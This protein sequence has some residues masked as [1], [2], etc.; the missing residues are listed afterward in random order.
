MT[1][2][3]E[4]ALSLQPLRQ[5]YAPL[6]W[7]AATFFAIAFLTRLVLLIKTGD[8]VPAQ[9]TSWLYLFLVGA[10]YDL[11]A[12]VYFAWPLVLFL[13][14]VPQRAYATRPTRAILALLSLASLYVLMFV[15]AAEWLFWD[16][17]ASRFNF[18]AVD[19]LVYSREV[20]G[21]IRASYPVG[22]LL[23][24][25]AIVAAAIVYFTRGGWLP[26]ADGSRLRARSLVTAAWLVLTIAF[27]A[28]VDSDD[29]NRSSNAYVNELAG[30]GIYEFFSA[31]RNNEL[32]YERLYKTLPDATA[33]AKVRELLQTP[34][35][36]FLSDD[37]HDIS[38]TIAN[39]GPEKHL[40]VVLISV[41]SLS[42]EYLT[43]FG[44]TKGITPNLDALVD[45]SLFFDNLYASGTR[46]VRGLE[47]LSLSV[48]PTPG[49][50]I[51]KRPDNEHLFSLGS[52]FDSKGYDSMFVYG[53]YGYFDNMN[54]FFEN[55]GYRIADRTNIPRDKVHLGNIWGVADEDL[56]TLAMD[57]AD[58][59]FASG[60][61][62][63]QHVM[64]TSNHPPFTYPAD[65]ID[66]PSGKGGRAGAVKYTDWALGDFLERAAT[67]PWFDDTV[68]VITAD[69][70]ASSWGRSSLPMNRYHIPLFV[71]APK[72]IEARR[73]D[74]L[75]SQIDIAPTIL[76]LLDFSYTS[77]FYGYD[78]LRLE[79][80]RER[81]VL[82][83]YQKAGYFRGDTLTILAPKQSVQQ[84]IPKFDKSGDATPVDKDNPDLVD[85]AVAYYQTA[86]YRF[87]NGLMRVEPAA[88]K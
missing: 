4:K 68:F 85:E 76:G 69:H 18:I 64:T 45:K 42:G 14:L 32:D 31:Y 33:F 72:H 3:P 37:P 61:P 63:F 8:G 67:K 36:H 9:P 12:F 34:E 60:K 1:D 74:R 75:M 16:E 50:S 43:T 81:L 2:I 54:Y 88:P 56:Y 25:L 71:Y 62:F 59:A 17:F 78:V 82:G 52:V 30:D 38:R 15:A 58:K 24:L 44:N 27:T 51:I 65:R 22:K 55:N 29:K 40:N 13:W 77:Q 11:I 84:S 70:C 79:P 10:A 83:N 7:L 26:R 39:P 41:E 21:N 48:P 19:Y 28:F 87:G 20:I 86:S 57:E 5:R 73:V 35:S 47:A 49:Q 46:T 23:A 53:G 6:L 66:I 80:G